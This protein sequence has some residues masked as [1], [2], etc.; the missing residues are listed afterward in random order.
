[1]VNIAVRAARNAGNVIV[2][3]LNQVDLLTVTE[4]SQ[5][6]FVSEVDNRAEQEII[7]TIQKAYPDHA[8]LAEESG[9]QGDNEFQWII[10]PLDGTTNFL[11]GFPQFAV[12]IA[13]T[14][15]GKPE[16]A[17]VFDPMRQEIFSASRGRGAQVNDRRMRVSKRPSLKGALLGTGI[18]YRDDQDLDT[19]L[20]TLR[21][22]IPGTAGVRR[23]G[24]AA[25]DLAYVAA[26]RLDGFWEFGL[27]PWDMAGGVLLIQEAG[28]IVTDFK[29]TT[30]FFESG[31]VVAGNLKIHE[32]MLKIIQSA[33]GG[34]S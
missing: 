3:A 27:K 15:R 9:S 29:G 4:K 28:G 17:V 16:H 20:K 32:E 30:D 11:H 23:P 2:R 34:R 26:S 10:D 13:V 5:N 18:P 7:R 22:L 19:Y 14:Y 25:L 21:A 6:D 8:I 12:S 24:S 33:T 31:N 1:M